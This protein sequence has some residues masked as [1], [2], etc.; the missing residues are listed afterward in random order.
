VGAEKEG[1]ASKDCKERE[2]A[3]QAGSERK[4]VHREGAGQARAKGV[5]TTSKESASKGGRGQE[6]SRLRGE[7]QEESES[8][9]FKGAMG[10]TMKGRGGEVQERSESSALK[11][12]RYVRRRSESCASERWEQCKQEVTV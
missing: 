1:I 4:G 11:G 5:H 7:V 2:R 10:G 8:S 9:V 12:R 3:V 6:R